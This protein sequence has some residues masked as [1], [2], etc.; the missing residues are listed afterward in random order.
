M[1]NLK[2]VVNG[3]GGRMGAALVKAICETDG[4]ELW[5][6]LERTGAKSLGKDA[7]LVAG[8]GPLNKIISD[9]VDAVLAQADAIVDFTAPAAS[10]VLAA[11]AAKLS[12]IHVIGT[13]G[14]TAEDEQAFVDAGENGA[15]IVKSGNM[16][17]GINLVMALVKQASK[18]LGEEFDIEV[19]EMHHNRKVDAPSGTA[20]MLGQ[21]AADGR[22][23]DL[24]EM[25]VK[26]REGITG[27]RETGTIGF[28]TLRGGTVV[29]NHSVILA[30]PGE[31]IEISHKAQ[32][33]SLFANGAVKALLWAKGKK[34]GYYSME[35]VLGLNA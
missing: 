28:A 18:S 7:G 35:D 29:G 5:G 3:A 32:D 10:V 20:L 15:C 24:D 21:A 11:K 1:S 2:I 13:T 9:D 22:G 33:R 8:L 6:A 14:C 19:L 30:G 4:L 17:L 23:I 31:I 26:S 25:A 27:A 16:S 34:P 12:L